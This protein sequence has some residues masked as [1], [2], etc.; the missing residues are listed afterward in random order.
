MNRKSGA[1]IIFAAAAAT[2]LGACKPRD[3]AAGDTLAARADSAGGRV[4]SASRAMADSTRRR[5]DSTTGA[6]NGWTEPSILG[7]TW[8]EQ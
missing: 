2:G 5:S 4:D 6:R 3:N 1:F 7:Y 8:G